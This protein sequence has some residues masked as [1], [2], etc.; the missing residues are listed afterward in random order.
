[1]DDSAPTAL[2]SPDCHWAG[3][4]LELSGEVIHLDLPLNPKPW[5]FSS[6]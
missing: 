2:G 6:R 1:M 5:N 4:L 3:A